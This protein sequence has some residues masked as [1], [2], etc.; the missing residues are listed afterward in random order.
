MKDSF[1][2]QIEVGDTLVY[3]TRH[4]SFQAAHMGTVRGFRTQAHYRGE[5]ELVRVEVTAERWLEHRRRKTVELSRPT[6]VV[7]CGARL[8][9]AALDFIK[10]VDEGRAFSRDSYGKFKAALAP[11]ASN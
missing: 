7:V 6:C 5:R 10:K 2:T 1:G 11:A 3:F 8:E 9:A 4:G